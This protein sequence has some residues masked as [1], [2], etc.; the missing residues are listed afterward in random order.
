MCSV[1]RTVTVYSIQYVS[2]RKFF[3]CGLYGNNLSFVFSQNEYSN[4]EYR[5]CKCSW[6][7]WLSIQYLRTLPLK[8]YFTKLFRLNMKLQIP[9][10]FDTDDLLAMY[11]IQT[12]VHHI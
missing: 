7:T 12:F 11:I 10:A 4:M 8:K 6:S 9:I 2:F 5:E 1:T 3:F